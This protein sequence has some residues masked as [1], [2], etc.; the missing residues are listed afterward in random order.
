MTELQVDIERCRRRAARCEAAALAAQSP[1]VAG[2]WREHER[3]W[4]RLADDPAAP[5]RAEIASLTGD[6]WTPGT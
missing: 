3:V 5:V 2:F 1:A 4:R 6:D